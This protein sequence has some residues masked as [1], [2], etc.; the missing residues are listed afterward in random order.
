MARRPSK[1]TEQQQ[2]YVDEVMLGSSKNKAAKTA[3]YAHAQNPE[4]S[5]T[6]QSELAVAREKLTDITQ[7]RRVDVVDGMLNGIAMAQMM[8]DPGNVIKGWSEVGKLLGHYAPEVKS[9]SLS[10][11]MSTQ[12]LRSKFE[13]LSDEEL[14]AIQNGEVVD[15]DS[16]FKD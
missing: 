8:S 9:I 12:R 7:I 1:I 5:R 4:A 15:V 2:T 13:S 10:L 16:K 11:S 14:I 3:G 6:V